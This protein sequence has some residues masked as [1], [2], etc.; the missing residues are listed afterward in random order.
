MGVLNRTTLDQYLQRLLTP[1]RFKDY[2][3][4]GLQIQG[5][6]EIQRLITGV[7]AS[8]DFIEAAVEAKAD[9]VLV[10]HGFFWRGESQCITGIKYGRIK[11]LMD[12]SVSLFAYHLPLDSHRVYGNNV[13]LAMRLGI[14]PEGLL[15]PESP[16]DPGNVGHFEEPLT[17]EA[18]E[19]RLIKALGQRPKIIPGAPAC[20]ATA[21]KQKVQSVAWCTGGA[22]SYFETAIARG[23]DVFITGEIS[24]PMVHLARESG[25]TY[26]AAGH[27]A[28]ERYGALALGQH[29][30]EHFEID[31]DFIDIDSPV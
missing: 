22:Q 25:V 4:N 2:C 26:V 20:K 5:K 24:E 9:A 3:P 17:L 11:A 7:T 19:D 23:V 28:T 18:L 12:A 14:T 13:Q 6:A 1:E 16:L 29:I 8:L 30:G 31:V 10:H 15:T 27:H 21:K